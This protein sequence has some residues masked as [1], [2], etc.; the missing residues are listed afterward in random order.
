MKQIILSIVVF[1]VLFLVMG[2]SGWY[3]CHYTLDC[4]VAE[5][6][7]EYSTFVTERGDEFTWFNE[8]DDSFVEG[9]TVRLTMFDNHTA[10]IKDDE[11]EKIVV[12]GN[13]SCPQ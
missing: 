12:C 4:N 3:E 1:V 7:T 5:I 8:D 9:D 6:N 2:I 13:P 11:I 10:N